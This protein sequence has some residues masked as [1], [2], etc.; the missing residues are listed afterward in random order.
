[1]TH[2]TTRHSR[3][4][5]LRGPWLV[6]LAM[7]LN[8]MQFVD[9]KGI[10]VRELERRAR[11][12]TNLSGM[13]RWGYIAVEPDPADKRPKPPRSAWLVRAKRGGM[14]ARAVWGPL[15][16]EMEQRWRDRFGSGE[17]DELRRSLGAIA[18]QIELELP[19]CLPILGYGLRAKSSR[20]ERCEPGARAN[21]SAVSLPLCTLLSRVLLA[22]TMDFERDSPLS[23]AICANV[24]RVLDKNG[25]RVQD[26][27][28]VAGISKEGVSMAL[29]FS[30]KKGLVAVATDA[31]HRSRR[32]N[33]T[34]KGLIAK[35]AYERFV[36]RIEARW[37]ERFGAQAVRELR[38]ALEPITGDGTSE[39]SPLFRG[40]EPY[41][42]GWRASVRKPT[43]LPH[44][45]LI[46]HRGGYPDGS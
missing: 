27:P 40:L 6:S 18:C 26:L 42:D 15:S 46:L 34:Q 20:F 32:V 31:A 19:D 4:A 5:D 36:G 14:K 35:S 17:V 7:W 8:C 1:M 16:A 33:L 28:A 11:T 24:L 23:L 21:N 41:P 30:G 29:G 12:P 9:E 3:G 10:S 2:R 44:Y 38:A 13:Q 22:F 43:T 39:G 25:G 37:V 45:P